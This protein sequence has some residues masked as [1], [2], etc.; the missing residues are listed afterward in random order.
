MCCIK[1]LTTNSIDS[2]LYICSPTKFNA[3]VN[4]SC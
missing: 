3:L 4:Q 1:K 2:V